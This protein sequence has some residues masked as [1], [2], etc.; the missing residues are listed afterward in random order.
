MYRDTD[1]IITIIVMIMVF[2]ARAGRRVSGGREEWRKTGKQMEE[3]E[4]GQI[5]R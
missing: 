2:V 5:E 1:D 3:I 4:I